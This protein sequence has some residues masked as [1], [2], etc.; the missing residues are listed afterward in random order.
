MKI[1]AEQLGSERDHLALVEW[2]RSFSSCIIAFSAGVD[3]SLLAFAAKEALSFQAHAVT[4]YS[5]SFSK[6]EKE[7]ARRVAREIGID[8]IEIEQND[9]SVDSYRKNGVDRCYFCR[10][11]LAK[12]IRPIRESLSI[13]VCVDGT[14]L[15]DLHSPRPGIRALR[16]AGFR[17]PLV[18][19]GFTKDRIR[20]TARAIG[21]SN[22]NRPSESCLSSRIAFG[23]PID[24]ETLRLVEE[25]EIAV[26]EITHARIVRVRTIGRDAQIELDQPSVPFGLQNREKIELALKEIG[27]SNVE[28]DDRGY[29]SGRML[30]MFVQD[31]S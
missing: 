9:L 24:E 23:Q 16:E 28:I 14:H 18:E 26:K 25:A 31:N 11:N 19:L 3:S 27:Y 10:G 21:L 4:S 30:E 5:S 12:A 15:D 22:W 13:D 7:T 1:L 29:V 17:A 2:F 8:L 6:S 20:A